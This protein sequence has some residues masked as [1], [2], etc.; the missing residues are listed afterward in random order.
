MKTKTFTAKTAEEAIRLGLSEWNVGED[1]VQIDIIEEASKGFL[2]FGQKDA[3]VRLTLLFDP[4][5]IAEE[6]LGRIFQGMG[7]EATIHSEYSE[8]DLKIKVEDISSEDKGILIGKRGNT[9]DSLQYLTG[10]TVNKSNRE[11]F[12]RVAIDVED[13]REKREET[14]KQLA[15][16]MAEKAKKTRRSIKLEPM[17]PYERR[18]IHSALQGVQGISTYSEG[19]EPFRRVVI[20]QSK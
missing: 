5:K 19:A 1:E 20:V 10:L 15:L 9:L 7:I 11:Q 12:I 14:L 2:G 8:G 6:F 18:T 16:R 17:N 13:Y 4:V 3:V